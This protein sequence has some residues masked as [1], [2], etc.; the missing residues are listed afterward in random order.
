MAISASWQDVAAPKRPQSRRGRRSR[1][2]LAARRHTRLVRILRV[3]LPVGACL[4]VAAFF[5]KVDL[6]L[7]GDLDLSAA[8]LSVTRN[9][10]IMDHPHLTGFAGDGREYSLSAD[11]AI[12]PLSK[13]SQVRLE[14]IE[15]KI[16]TAERGTT[17]VTAEA[18]DYDHEKRAIKLLGP[19]QVH[20]ADGYRLNMTDAE[21]DFQAGTLSSNH[22]ISI[23]Y[24]SSEV[25][26]DRLSVGDSGKHIVIE[27]RV[28]TVLMPPKRKNE[29]PAAPVVAE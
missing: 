22:P 26:G 13:P 18:G 10:V 1:A 23:G 28:R 15:A 7:P 19:I 24:G 20:S 16:T 5:V 29:V 14:T 12:Q 11:R 25:A 3:L 6:G 17:S 9:S 4:A 8:N 2:F 21:V 27:G